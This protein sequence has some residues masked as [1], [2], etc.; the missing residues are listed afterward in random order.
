VLLQQ[1][2]TTLRSSLNVLESVVAA[3]SCSPQHP[4]HQQAEELQGGDDSDSY[5]SRNSRPTL[6]VVVGGSSSSVSASELE[7]LKAMQATAHG[8]AG[9]EGIARFSG[10]QVASLVQ[11]QRG[12]SSS[13]M[14]Q[15]IPSRA[16]M[17]QLHEAGARCGC[18][19]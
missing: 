10:A 3:R 11:Q 1:E 9:P 14:A 15:G 7:R 5:T 12:N 16:V 4:Q 18:E 8:V 19:A 17:Q 6:P 2:R 13:S